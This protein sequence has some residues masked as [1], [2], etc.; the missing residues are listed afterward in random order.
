M[1]LHTTQIMI[2]LFLFDNGYFSPVWVSYAAW[3]KVRE[4]LKVQ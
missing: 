3:Q 1:R 2:S 4:G